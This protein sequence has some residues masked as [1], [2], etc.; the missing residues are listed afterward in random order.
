MSRR[1][2]VPFSS[3][4]LVVAKRADDE[5]IGDARR[6]EDEMD[7]KA[8]ASFAR[9]RSKMV[10]AAADFMVVLCLLEV[11]VVSGFALGADVSL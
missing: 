4:L 3:S 8:S 7:E 1:E 9:E 10:S 6:D 5:A 2:R 11:S